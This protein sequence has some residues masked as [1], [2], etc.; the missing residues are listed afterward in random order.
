MRA[1][2]GEF[3]T[4]HDSDDWSHPQKLERQMREL[5]GNSQLMAVGSNWVRVTN[6]MCV[7]GPWLPSEKFVEPN[8]SSWI[9]RRVVLDVIG[10]GDKVN[11]AGGTEFLWRLSQD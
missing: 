8:V 5:L 1:A 6:D 10:W 9:F 7:V 2:K 3:V 11:V 4:V